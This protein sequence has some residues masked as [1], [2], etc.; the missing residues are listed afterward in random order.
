[1]TTVVYLALTLASLGLC[2]WLWPKRA[3]MHIPARGAVVATLV[4]LL[5]VTA[6]A[7][8]ILLDLVGWS[9]AAAGH[10]QRILGLAAQHMSLPLIGLAALFLARGLTWGPGLWG[11]V[12]LGIMGFYELF[13]QLNLASEYLWLVNLIGAAA[14][15]ATAV[16]Y[17]S[18]NGRLA[19]LAVVAPVCLLAPALLSEHTPMD[20]LFLASS[21]A[22][23]LVPGLVA[24]GL[25]VGLLA[26]Q[27][28]NSLTVLDPPEST[29]SS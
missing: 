24:A 12:I 28:H 17:L 11:K 19:A 18:R 16:L 15:L 26:E 2:V 9:N 4:G 5:L 7:A 21:Q 1:M 25:A 27:A 20:V 29:S 13:R 3:A 14:L 6:S 10:A 8:M 22:S 23:W